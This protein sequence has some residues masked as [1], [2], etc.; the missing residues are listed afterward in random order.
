V[1][2]LRNRSVDRGDD[3][4]LLAAT[5]RV[6][7]AS[8]WLLDMAQGM[9]ADQLVRRVR[10]RARDNR[11]A[12]VVVDYVQSMPSPPRVTN[13]T[14]AIEANL[15]ALNELAGRD[16]LAVLVFSQFNRSYAG[17][18]DKRPQ[19]AD[20]RDSG[21]LEQIAKLILGMHYPAGHGEHT[22]PKGHPRV[23]QAVKGS[24]L[25]L[26]VLKN[27]QGEDGACIV[28]E[29]DRARGRIA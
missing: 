14:L 23:G 28:V 18:P 7:R 8:S 12:L 24:D 16:D 22:Y 17:R 15:L 11:T 2:R 9:S 29:Y 13:K 1:Q 25:E 3:A 6:H 27:H 5:D 10:G 26:L 19:R 4:A 21:A 20:F